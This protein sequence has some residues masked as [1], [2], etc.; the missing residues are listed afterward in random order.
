MMSASLLTLHQYGIAVLMQTESKTIFGSQNGPEHG[1][2][3]K[4]VPRWHS[5]D[6]H[7]IPPTGVLVLRRRRD[8]AMSFIAHPRRA[9]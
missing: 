3:A 5:L 2:G 1:A 7:L 9:E 4:L 8:I 6:V